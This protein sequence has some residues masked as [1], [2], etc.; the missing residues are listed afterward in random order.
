M[1]KGTGGS[2]G[3]TK[4][5]RFWLRHVT[6]CMRSGEPATGY[7]KRH[8]LEVGAYYEAKRRLIARGAV[9]RSGATPSRRSVFTQVVATDPRRDRSGGFRIR[10]PGGALLEWERVP[11]AAAI[12]SL[13]RRLER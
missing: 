7:A 6:A 11:E 3:L 5:D 12:E 10:L 9:P 8:D 2:P 4:R 1:Q 13:I